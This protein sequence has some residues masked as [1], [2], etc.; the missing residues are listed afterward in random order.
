MSLFVS[1][2]LIVQSDNVFDLL[3]NFT[4]AMFI[5]ELD[6]I[7]FGLAERSYLAGASREM[8]KR[9]KAERTFLKQ[10]DKHASGSITTP[11]CW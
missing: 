2:V 8:L 1:Y 3:L 4:A 5:S 7:A 9:Y 11:L 10:K 6:D